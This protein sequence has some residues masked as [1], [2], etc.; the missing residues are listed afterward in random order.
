MTDRAYTHIDRGAATAGNRW[1]ERRWRLFSGETIGLV[2]KARQWDWVTG[3][4][5]DV[6]YV[7]N[8][9]DHDFMSMGAVDISEGANTFGA[10]ILIHRVGDTLRCDTETTILHNAPGLVRRHWIANRTSDPIT[11]EEFAL[12][13]YEI[14]HDN[15]VAA[16]DKFEETTAALKL[17]ADIPAVGVQYRD[18]SLLFGADSEV[19]YD[20]FSSDPAV[21]AVRAP[22]SIHLEKHEQVALP[23]TYVCAYTGA[24]QEAAQHALGDVMKAV[25]DIV[26]ADENPGE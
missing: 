9:A 8:G 19:E 18:V 14:E 24:M 17:T 25:R 12:D 3:P 10:T 13:R 4:C 21:C 16:K 26:D 22:E 5:G 20:L 7:M 2:L 15:V 6:S 23:V 11:I 1:F